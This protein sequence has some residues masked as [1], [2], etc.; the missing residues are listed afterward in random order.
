M[1][2]LIKK[3]HAYS[4]YLELRDSIPYWEAQLPELKYRLEEMQWNQQQ[5]ETELLTLKE[6]NFFQRLFGRAEEKKER[7]S[8]QIREISGA[9]TAAQWEL[10][11]LEKQIREGREELALLEDSRNHYEAAKAAAALSPAG[12]SRLMMEQISAFA[13]VALET[14]WH[15][16]MALEDARPWMSRDARTT[17]VGPDNRKMECLARAE[18]AAA[19]LREILEALPEGI[20]TVGSYLREPHDY[21][22][23]VTS[24][25]K[26]LDRL[27][28]A[29]EQIRTVRT[30][31]KLILG[32]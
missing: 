6:P 14:A 24:E 12:E 26:Q 4:R 5:K 30:Q 8:K 31:L 9:K 15:V 29:Q 1:E 13:P 28:R 2:D 21:I 23:G 32:E 25:F 7:I 20:A 27:E 18:A 3:L 17:G 10:E 11:G 19:L 16:L 22:Y